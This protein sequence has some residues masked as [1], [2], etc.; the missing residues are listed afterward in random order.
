[1][2]YAKMDDAL[3]PLGE[4]MRNTDRVRLTAPGT[5]LSFSIKDID[6]V[7]CAG[8][9]N[10]PDGEAFTAPVKDSV[11]GTIQFNTPTI[12]QGIAFDDMRLSFKDGKVIDASANHSKELNDI[13]DTDD[14]SRFVGEFAIGVNP[15]ITRPMRDILFDEKMA[16]SVHFTPRNAYAEADNGNRSQVHWDMV[17][18]QTPEN[19]GGEISFDDVL[20]RKDGQFVVD[21]LLGLNPKNLLA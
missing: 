5:D 6:A 1:M 11:N 4:L 2:N 21:E 3:Q 10:I 13:L 7:A 14:G 8:R 20:I 12:Y 17:L 9:H 18:Q 16:G 19:G 15:H